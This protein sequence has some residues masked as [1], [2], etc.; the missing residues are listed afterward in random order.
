MG[1]AQSAPVIN[2]VLIEKF[3]PALLKHSIVFDL[4][5]IL[6]TA[7]LPE[8]FI[9]VG[10]F[11]SVAEKFP[12]TAS[13]YVKSNVIF[14]DVSASVNELVSTFYF[15]IQ[16][17][18]F[19]FPHPRMQIQPDSSEKILSAAKSLQGKT[20]IWKPRFTHRGFHLH[21]EIA[22]EW[23]RGFL[24][25]D[26]AIAND[27][28]TWLARNQQNVFEIVLLSTVSKADTAK[29]LTGPFQLAN[30]LAIHCGISLGTQFHQHKSAHL[31]MQRTLSGKFMP[32]YDLERKLKETQAG[33]KVYIEGRIPFD[34]MS[35]DI[36]VSDSNPNPKFDDELALIDVAY[37]C[38]EP[39]KR[40]LF[41]KVRSAAGPTDPKYGDLP[42]SL[43]PS[44]ADPHIGVMSHTKMIYGLADAIAPIHGGSDYKAL[45]DFM[46]Q[47]ASKRPCW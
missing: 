27:T 33:I 7:K 6:E 39:S 42:F 36:G 23:T 1:C 18:G 40:D 19:L 14:I 24:Q 22:N 31:A 30:H 37:K 11:L 35:L 28:V 4:K 5:A 12:N 17:L 43:L 41:L 16:R 8:G 29:F 25:G 2:P 3:S 20:L 46:Q 44:L 26:S 34:F 38:L 13:V 21:T 47:E 9:E 15:A 10:K 32:A 45:K